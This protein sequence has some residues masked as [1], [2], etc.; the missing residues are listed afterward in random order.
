MSWDQRRKVMIDRIMRCEYMKMKGPSWA[1]ISPEAKRFVERMLQMNPSQRPTAAQAL[2]DP[3]I[4]KYRDH[5]P[6]NGMPAQ[7][8]QY[9]RKLQL[10]RR[11]RLLIAEELSEDGIVELKFALEAH[12]P[13]KED[14]ITLK[15]FRDTLVQSNI[16]SDKADSVF[17]GHDL[18]LTEYTNYIV[19]LNDALDRKERLQEELILDIFDT[20]GASSGCTI[21]KEKLRDV[22]EKRCVAKMTC[23]SILRAVDS[24]G[25]GRSVSCQQ[26]INHL[27]QQEMRR[28]DKICNCRQEEV[29]VGEAELV[30][31]TNAVIPGGRRDSKADPLFVYDDVSKSLRKFQPGDEVKQSE[32]ST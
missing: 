22:L 25:D 32:L 4:E 9:A 27:K 23:D 21:S 13:K 3:W 16:S 11:V 17:A 14:R 24:I 2:S 31:E 1:K 15:S 19:L 20:C 18:D 7:D 5:K 29:A 28:V 30:D 26:L 10:Q 6:T 12:D 8:Q